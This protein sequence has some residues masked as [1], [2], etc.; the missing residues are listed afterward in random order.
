MKSQEITTDVNE[1]VSNEFI[2]KYVKIM[3]TIVEKQLE[4]SVNINSCIYDFHMLNKGN[5]WQK[6]KGKQKNAY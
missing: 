2:K 4:L 1:G 3:R 5:L 6:A